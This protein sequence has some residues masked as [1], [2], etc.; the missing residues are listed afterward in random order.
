[1]TEVCQ[2]CGFDPETQGTDFVTTFRLLA[3][4]MLSALCLP[5]VAKTVYIDDTLYAPVR[6]GEGTQYRI[7][8]NG[9]KSGTPVELLEKSESGYSKIRTP[10]GT[11]GWIVSRYLS[12]QP[13]A[14]DRLV[15][16]NKELD[17]T[18]SQL[19]EVRDKLDAVQSERDNLASSESNLEDRSQK[20]ATELEKVKSISANAITLDRR[21]QELQQANQKLRSD[22]EVLT[23]EKERLEA[24]NDS[25]FMLIGAGLV[26]AGIVIA[27]ILPALKSSKKHDTWA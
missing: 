19:A 3:I 4:V 16:A 24:K 25:D 12:E 9:L 10:D 11:E 1:M 7:L 20:L 21:N 26:L 2:N 6:S 13:I 14:R 27:L 17:R 22:M 15:A 5:V 8:N 18:R 23:A